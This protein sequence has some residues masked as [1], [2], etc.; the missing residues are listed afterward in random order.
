MMS[1]HN[2]MGINNGGNIRGSK[3]LGGGSIKKKKKGSRRRK[4]NEIYKATDTSINARR[5]LS[6]L[7]I[8]KEN[9]I[10]KSPRARE[11]ARL[12]IAEGQFDNAPEVSDIAQLRQFHSSNAGGLAHP[13]FGFFSL[14]PSTLSL[15]PLSAVHLFYPP[16]PL[17]AMNNSNATQ[18]G[19]SQNS[20]NSLGLGSLRQAAFGAHS[21]A[22]V[23]AVASGMSASASA[24][25]SFHNPRL[26]NQQ[27]L[28]QQPSISTPSSGTTHQ[29]LAQNHIGIPVIATQQQLQ[30]AQAAAVAAATAS[31][32]QPSFME[33]AAAVKRQQQLEFTLQQEVARSEEH[34]KALH[35]NQKAVMRQHMNGVLTPAAIM[36]RQSQ[37]AQSQA[38][39][40]AQVGH[41]QHLQSREQSHLEQQQ[42][43]KHHAAA[44]MASLS[45]QQMAPSSS[46]QPLTSRTRNVA[47]ASG[48]RAAAAGSE[49]AR[50]GP[51]S[52]MMALA[53]ASE[54]SNRAVAAA[55]LLR[56]YASPDDRQQ[57]QATMPVMSGGLKHLQPRPSTQ[58]VAA[59]DDLVPQMA[60]NLPLEQQSQLEQLKPPPLF[61]MASQGSSVHQDDGSTAG[62]KARKPITTTDPSPLTTGMDQLETLPMRGYTPPDT[63]KKY[64]V[65]ESEITDC[66]VYVIF[67]LQQFLGGILFLSSHTVASDCSDEEE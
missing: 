20:L 41:P 33:Y 2:Q 11:A 30:K 13:P 16:I 34:F 5:Q 31:A 18:S 15:H 49:P 60:S 14:H 45:Q 23:A 63:D 19:L 10:V 43:Q 9:N 67:R 44:V 28:Q 48:D 24:L 42:K 59:T 46:V 35:E 50:A 37:Q 47:V 39:A 36:A 51:M 26:L 62:S 38:Q 21:A 66:D 40:Q 8:Q 58:A 55:A 3:G 12:P 52:A 64:P 22:G 4:D 29:Q 56:Q 27:R 53:M 17:M 57:Q 7:V 61:A 32:G 6:D 25:S 1:G 65:R 54:S